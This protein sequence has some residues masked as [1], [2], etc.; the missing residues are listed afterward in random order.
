M[1]G[2]WL[3]PWQP[4]RGGWL[5]PWQ[6][7]RGGW[8]QP[9][10]HRSP[11]GCRAIERKL[12]TR[13]TQTVDTASLVFDGCQSWLPVHSSKLGTSTF[14]KVGKG[15]PAGKKKKTIPMGYPAGAPFLASQILLRHLSSHF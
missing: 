13:W 4:M 5:Q 11:A 3:Q 2:G 10:Q 1:R 9:W 12:D 7:M 6:P 8:L 14:I 15:W